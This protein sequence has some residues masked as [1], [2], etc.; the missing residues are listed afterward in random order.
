MSPHAAQPPSRLRILSLNCWGLK[1]ISKVRNERLAEIGNQ[2]AAAAHPPDIVGL[3][4]CWTQQDYHA[5][6]E[7][8]RHRL[9]YGKFYHSGIFGGG[10]VIL[11]RWPI[12][13]SNMT[14]YPLNGRPA[15]F[16]RGDWF[17]G[18]GVAHARIRMGP[19]P[20]DVA[21][22]FCTHLHAPYE[23]EPHDSYICHRTAQ[24]WEITKLMRGAAERGHLVIGLGDFNM[25]PLSLA[26]RI[27]ETHSPVRDAWRILYPDSSVGAALDK[28]EQ[29]RNVPM[30]SAEHN[31]TQNGATCDSALNTWRW[32]KAHSQRLA[33]GENVQIEPTVD[34]PHAK[35]LDYIFFSSATSGATEEWALKEA[36]V[37]M[38]TRHPTL[39]CSLSDHFSVEATLERNMEESAPRSESCAGTLPERYLPIK[40]YDE[41]LATIHKY[42][43]RE[44]TQRRL[45]MGHFG[46]QFLLTVG[47]FIGVWWSPHNYVAFILMFLSSL[48][49]SVG[50]LE[51]LMGG[52][53]VASELR[54]LKEFEWEVRNTRQRALT[55]EEKAPS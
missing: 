37:G 29:L 35:R 33:N 12:E 40:T 27:I 49:L 52:L 10:L 8:T 20:R 22:V 17:V 41:I 34:D 11:S 30:P 47:C 4:E 24:A 5:I 1:Y 55:H 38:T 18:K 45:R 13:E 14:Q 46:F 32:N 3:Q 19:R 36:N 23:A 25:I 53:F 51:G 39:Y 28:V 44:R 48:G 42:E 2:I 43:A 26:H 21:E 50:V 6:R 54:A 31:L 9:P 15:A 7:R 16:Y